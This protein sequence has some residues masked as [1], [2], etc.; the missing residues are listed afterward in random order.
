MRIAELGSSEVELNRTNRH[1]SRIREENC[2]VFHFPAVNK[3]SR[4]D[5][6]FSNA[7]QMSRDFV[8]TSPSGDSSTVNKAGIS[9][10]YYYTGYWNPSFS[11]SRSY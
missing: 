6:R 5:I 9:L 8:T 2:L 10:I 11:G 1:E 4:L 7:F 3:H